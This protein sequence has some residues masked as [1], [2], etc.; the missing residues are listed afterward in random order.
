LRQIKTT[1]T[2]KK[3]ELSLKDLIIEAIKE[4]KGQEIVV[5]NLKEL[6]QSIADYFII[7]HG[8]SNT[9]VETIADFI[10]RHTR[11]EIRERPL[12][13]EGT[14]N[15]QW[16]LLDYSDVIVHVFQEPYRRFYNLEDLWADAHQELIVAD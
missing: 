2:K 12:H 14:N 11:T 9:Q 13:V 5:I 10:E 7:C 1:M 8:N 6:K 4:K 3:E 16:V 15:A